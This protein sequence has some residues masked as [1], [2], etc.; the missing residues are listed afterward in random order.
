MY[1]RIFWG[2]VLIGLG[3]FFIMDQRGV[4]DFD[5]GDII[6]T[7]WPI[8]LIYYGLKGLIFQYRWGHGIG[9]GYLSPIILTTIGVY[10][11]GRNIDYIEMSVGD[12]FQYVIPFILI[13]IG[14][15]IILRPGKRQ[16][17]QMPGL[18][19]EERISGLTDEHASTPSGEPTYVD[20]DIADTDQPESVTRHSPLRSDIHH[21]A[22]EGDGAHDTGSHT[23]A[24][25]HFSFIGDIHIGSAN[26]QLKPLNINH[27]IGDSVIDLTR[28]SIPE[29]LTKITVGSLIGDVKVML[30]QDHEVEA[31]VTMSSF[32][33][34]FD[35][36][37]RVEGGMMKNRRDESPHYTSARKKIQITVNMFIGDFRIERV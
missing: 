24:E 28:A 11:L 25:N 8:I 13:L 15:I 23:K 33:G 10:F 35:V 4:I 22:R 19:E 3:V 30:P 31:S 14:I 29:G 18:Q 26:W 34:D 17:E 20:T 27:F 9:F 2:V 36:F 6:T 37:G 32:I 12:F 1:N 5:I 7:Y 21:G 16:A